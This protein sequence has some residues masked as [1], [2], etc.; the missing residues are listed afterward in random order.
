MKIFV[1]GNH[2]H[3]IHLSTDIQCKSQLPNAFY[4]ICPICHERQL[5][6][7]HDVR[8]EVENYTTGGTIIGGLIG[9]FGGPLGLIVGGTIGG[10][11]GKKAE[12]KERRRVIRFLRC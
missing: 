7:L 11:L 5:F 9:L 2:G 1:I 3:K 12:D 6:Y 10:V 4:I 8:V